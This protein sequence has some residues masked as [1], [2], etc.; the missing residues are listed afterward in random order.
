M[1][2]TRFIC[3]VPTPFSNELRISA[4]SGQITL[5]TEVQEGLIL[6]K[7]GMATF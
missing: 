7:K 6:T 1:K 2:K 4:Q 3:F 5:V